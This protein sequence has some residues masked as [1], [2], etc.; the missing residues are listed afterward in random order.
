MLKRKSSQTESKSN[1]ESHVSTLPEGVTISGDND[2][3]ERLLPVLVQKGVFARKLKT[4]G[5]AYHSHHMLRLGHEYEGLL[6]EVLPSLGPSLQFQHRATFISS[7]AVGVKSSDFGAYYWRQNLE[8]QVRFAQAI[9][10]IQKKSDHVF[11]E[12]GPHSSLELPI[13]QTLAEANIA[14]AQVKYAAPIRRNI[15]ALKSILSFI[16]SLWLQG[17]T[18]NWSKVNGLHASPES[19]K[20]SY[21]V[22]INLPPYRFNYEK[23][24][25]TESRSSIEC[26]QRVYRRHELLGSLMPGG[27]GRDFIFRNILRVHDI[28]WVK[29]H[30][31]GETIVF[32]GTGYLAMAMEAIMQAK[33]VKN[34]T[35]PSFF[36]S[37]VNITNAL[38]LSPEHLSQTEIFLSLHKS[39][40]TNTATSSQWWE[41]NVSTYIDGS[42]ISHA[43]GSIAIQSN[44][45]ELVSKYQAPT[46]SLEPTAKRT[47]YER[48]T[49]QG[50]NYGPAFQIVTHFETPRMKS[51]LFCTAEAPLLTVYDDLTTEYPVHPITLDVLFQL[52]AVSAASG[53]PSDLRAV[54]PTRITSAIINTAIIPSGSPC[55]INSL[56]Q[57][58]GFGS[59][60]AG[61]ELIQAD[62]KVAVQFD[63]VKMLPYSAGTQSVRKAEKR[64]PVLR[65]LWKPD[66]YGLGFMPAPAMEEFLQGFSRGVNSPVSDIPLIKLGGVLDL[67]VHK[68]HKHEFSN[69]RM[70]TMS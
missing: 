7:V 38:A 69:L 40:L 62:G 37:N 33:N 27:N 59:I 60:E 14:A 29:D 24:M 11:I 67:L 26:R 50:L 52:A 9:D 55:H 20:R 12:L 18:V 36:F 56:V 39:N 8:S 35:R 4:G 31:L 15:G 64:H 57:R 46:D 34:D 42:S 30:Q 41:F 13:K 43:T 23:V 48:L 5:Q 63:Q 49:Q 44:K 45:F 70:G 21:R 61:A 51:G 58:T 2:A 16:G 65:L 17:C 3:V 47:W 53:I 22:V 54:V 10:F 19:S 1:L 66:A 32:P 6:N 28:P 25:W 68:E